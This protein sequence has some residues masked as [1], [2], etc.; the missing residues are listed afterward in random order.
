MNR[1]FIL[2]AV[3]LFFWGIGEGL[4]IYFQPL[5]LQEMGADSIM[6]GGILGITGIVMALAQI[7]AGLISDRLGARPVMA[8]AWVI[9]TIAVWFM[10]S[11]TSLPLFAVGLIIY[12]T[13][14]FSIAPMNS[15]LS[16][17]RGKLSVSQALTIP[18]AMYHLGAVLGPITGGQIAQRLGFRTLYLIAGV[19]F[20][21]ST[22]L[23]FLIEKNP[24]A[25]HEDM[26]ST[27]RSGAYKNPAFLGFVLITFLTMMVLYLPQPLTPNFLQNQQGYNSSMIG[28]LGTFGSLGNAVITLSLGSLNPMRGLL[29][30]QILMSFSSILF[31]KGNSPV[32]FGMGYFFFGGY[33]LSR[34]MVLAFARPL[35]HPSETGMAFG[36]LE[37]ANSVA[38]IIAPVLAGILYAKNPSLPYLVVL[39]SLLPVILATWFGL[40]MIQKRS[41]KKLL[42][43]EGV[44]PK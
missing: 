24:T 38:V 18:N 1:N 21:I 15:Y 4:F 43:G 27:S 26:Q 40:P 36:I 42:E 13:S 16:S 20:I 14:A 31:F 29:V 7:P 34:S 33:R 19:L 5:Y 44:N 11:A 6:I 25:H 22:V 9:G 30:G 17:V 12:G 8:A 39:I 23:I 2:V 28:L 3:S 10:A 35:V 41:A 37:T 32:F